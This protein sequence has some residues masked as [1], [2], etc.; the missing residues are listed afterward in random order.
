M[1]FQLHTTG[2]RRGQLRLWPTEM[3][4]VDEALAAQP[5]IRAG[6]I[7]LGEAKAVVQCQALTGVYGV[8]RNQAGGALSWPAVTCLDQLRQL[9]L[10]R[11]N[12]F[13]P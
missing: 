4:I 13:L 7:G 11:R 5:H 1:F 8:P 10:N 12:P 3:Q 6:R 2:N 9:A